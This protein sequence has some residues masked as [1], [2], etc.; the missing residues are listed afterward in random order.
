MLD[1]TITLKG[2]KTASTSVNSLKGFRL[3]DKIKNKLESECPGIVSCADL[4]TIAARDAVILVKRLALLLPFLRYFVLNKEFKM[5]L[6][7]NYMVEV[8]LQI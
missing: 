7:L 4:L 8:A 1:D 6:Q 5:E 2:E 3:V